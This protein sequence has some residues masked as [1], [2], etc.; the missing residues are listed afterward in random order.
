MSDTVK[1]NHNGQNFTV[2]LDLMDNTLPY[3]HVNY[4]AGSKFHWRQLN[5]TS[6]LYDKVAALAGYKA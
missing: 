4:P 2:Y 1:I 3:I 5:H 6:K